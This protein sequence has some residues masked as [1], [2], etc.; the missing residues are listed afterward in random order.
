MRILVIGGTRFIGLAVTRTLLQQGHTVAIF[1][2]GQTDALLPDSVVRIH[3]DVDR[4]QGSASALRGFAPDVVVHNIVLHDDHVRD[5]QAVFAGVASKFVMT[6]S[7]DVYQV[8]GRL[9]GIEPGALIAEPADERSPLRSVW[10]LYRTEGMAADHRLYRY[11]KIPAEREALNH[12]TLPGVVL[13]L[14][15]VI[16]EGDWQRRLLPFIKPMQDQRPALVFDSAYAHWCSTYGYVE[17]VAKA[18]ALCITDER[19]NGQIYNIADGSYSTLE[20]AQTV[21]ALMGWPGRLISAP[22]DQLPAALHFGHF[23]QDLV[24]LADRIRAELGFT[25]DFTFD[26]GVARTVAWDIANP[27]DPLPAE[28]ADYSA[29]DEA[30]RA[31]A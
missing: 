13:R 20:L 7:M 17:N 16:G 18:M 31:L 10:Y 28:L 19:A 26:E 29:Q 23:P 14:P 2:R 15:M 21:K 11:D 30:L 27:P 3:G 5:A 8:F 1:N 24:V 12:P 6:S 4:L 9:N 22:A 25:P